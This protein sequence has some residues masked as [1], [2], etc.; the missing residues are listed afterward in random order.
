[1]D[2]TELSQTLYKTLKENINDHPVNIIVA[3]IA[4][5]KEKDLF[6]HSGEV[7]DIVEVDMQDAGPDYDAYIVYT[8]AVLEEDEEE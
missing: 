1:M 3:M 4:A 5:M 8:D 2:E 7:L 6:I